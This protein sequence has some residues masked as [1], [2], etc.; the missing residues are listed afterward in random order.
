MTRHGLTRLGSGWV[1]VAL[2]TFVPNG[3]LAHL[4][5][6]IV[7][8]ATFAALI[9]IIIWSAL[10]VVHSADGLAEQ[11]G[12]PYGTLVLTLSVVVIE[13]ALIA[14][15][16]LSGAPAPTLGRDTMFAILMIVLNGAVGLGLLIGGQRYLQ[17]TFNLQGA[18]SYLALIIPLTSIALVLPNF[19]ISTPDGSFTALQ[20]IAFSAFTVA[21]YAIFLLLQTGR[22]RHFFLSPKVAGQPGTTE[23]DSRVER[24]VGAWLQA[25]YLVV[26]IFPIVILAESL[27]VVLEHGLHELQAPEEIG[28]VLI[29]MIV[30]APEGIAAVRA[31]AANELQR[32]LNICLGSATSTLGLTVP[33]VLAIGLLSGTKVV[34]G[35]SDTNTVLLVTTLLLSAVTFSQPATTML[36]GAVHLLMFFMFLVLLWAP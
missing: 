9:A 2:F 24:H 22:H 25:G 8:V 36:Q 18:A 28:G 11:L 5:S 20:A 34:L 7:A 10:G 33:A 26:G 15:V 19:T 31:A 13:V 30:F 32:A 17:Q 27:A 16:M 14:A 3:P 29:A 6:P 12:E 35:L 1:A 21:L 23:G 4:D